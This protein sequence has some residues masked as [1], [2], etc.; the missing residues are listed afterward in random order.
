MYTHWIGFIF[1][2]IIF[3]QKETG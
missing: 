2:C 1:S 3:P